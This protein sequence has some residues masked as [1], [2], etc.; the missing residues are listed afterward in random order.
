M[1]T[2]A[3]NVMAARRALLSGSGNGPCLRPTVIRGWIAMGGEE[4][5]S[6]FVGDC[7]RITR[8]KMKLSNVMGRI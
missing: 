2:A 4:L 5:L 7:G 6:I 1:E 3:A 8:K